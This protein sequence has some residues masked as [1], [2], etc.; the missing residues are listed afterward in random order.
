MKERTKRRKEQK[1]DE[2]EGQ[3]QNI[4]LTKMTKL[5]MEVE[6]EESE[7]GKRSKEG[8]KKK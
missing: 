5:N 3:K 7:L 2:G 8:N 1:T 6:K 4:K